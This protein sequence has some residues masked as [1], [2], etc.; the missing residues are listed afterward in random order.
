MDS[1]EIDRCMRLFSLVHGRKPKQGEIDGL[2]QA[3]AS[4]MEFRVRLVLDPELGKTLAA[5]VDR[6]R[7][8]VP[9]Q[10]HVPSRHVNSLAHSIEQL[11]LRIDALDARLNKHEQDLVEA[12]KRLDAAASTHEGFAVDLRECR[13]AA[14]SFRDRLSDVVARAAD[15]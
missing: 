11:L 7:A 4:F 5:V 10:Q 8:Q 3:S 9:R 6:W 14:V 12:V 2:L 1:S 15:H 13:A